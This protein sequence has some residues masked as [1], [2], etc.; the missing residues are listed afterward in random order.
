MLAI[1]ISNA[2]DPY[3]AKDREKIYSEINSKYSP[4]EMQTFADIGAEI[5]EALEENPDQD[6]LGELYMTLNL[7][8]DHAGQF[9]TPYNVCKMMAA[10]TYGADLNGQLE[11]KDWISVND[12]ACGGGATLIAFANECLEHHVNYQTDV[13][14]V[15]QDLDYV[16]ACM[17]YIQLSLLGCAGYVVIGNTL[18]NPSASYDEK[19]LLPIDNGN[20]WYTPMYN[21]DIWLARRLKAMEEVTSARVLQSDMRKEK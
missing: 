21:R 8:N 13:L 5:I 16:V 15:A 6:L 7:G 3:H 19:G 20:V 10:M 17:C 1:S 11:D 18:T 12:C 4:K 14:F 9:F 2:T